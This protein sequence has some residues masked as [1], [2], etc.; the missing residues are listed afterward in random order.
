MLNN[1]W[2]MIK[3]KM[4]DFVTRVS[5]TMLN[6]IFSIT[7]AR[8]DFFGVLGVVLS[9]Q[10]VVYFAVTHLAILVFTLACPSMFK[11]SLVILSS[12]ARLW[13]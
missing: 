1:L 5:E 3:H 11:I 2:K 6:H 9:F 10:V 7:V 13:I 8:F 12:T 4:Q